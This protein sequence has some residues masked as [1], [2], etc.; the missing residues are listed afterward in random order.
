MII[1]VL[2]FEKLVGETPSGDSEQPRAGQWDL[3]GA[4]MQ[5]A[6]VNKSAAPGT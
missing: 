3:M 1:T 5:T 4:F 6:G 2:I